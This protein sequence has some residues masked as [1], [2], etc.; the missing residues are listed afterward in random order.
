MSSHK[1][2]SLGVYSKTLTSLRFRIKDWVT[3][4]DG[5]RP[6]SDSVLVLLLEGEGKISLRAFT[7]LVAKHVQLS[8]CGTFLSDASPEILFVFTFEYL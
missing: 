6:T 1:A 7:I 4:T 2:P 8:T 5:Y 3:I